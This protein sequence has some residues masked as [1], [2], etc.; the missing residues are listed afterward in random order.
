MA[1]RNRNPK[2]WL[3]KQPLWVMNSG[4]M[5]FGS[6]DRLTGVAL[7]GRVT[8]LGM[9]PLHAA[10]ATDA[11]RPTTSAHIGELIRMNTSR[12]Y[13]EANH[14]LTTLPRIQE[15]EDSE[16]E[17]QGDFSLVSYAP[18][19]RTST[20]VCCA[21]S[22]RRSLHSRPS[23]QA[24]NARLR[25]PTNGFWQRRRT[26]LPAQAHG[27]AQPADRCGTVGAPLAMRLDLV[28]RGRLELAVQVSRDREQESAAF[29]GGRS[30]HTEA[31]MR[32]L[33]ISRA[34]CSRCFTLASEY[35]V[36]VA[37]SRVESPSIS[38]ITR[39]IRYVGGSCDSAVRN[40]RSTP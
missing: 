26:R 36:T 28:T 3:P 27:R 6:A 21:A 25:A 13:R 12:T 2:G 18:T 19:S 34:R 7:A 17:P 8:S 24:P 33:S 10:S 32:S 1:S 29:S 31:S 22:L 23:E 40:L 20:A 30:A 16:G 38:R 14:V 39:I 5:G 37:T 4:M 35:P 15:L 9:G 11:D